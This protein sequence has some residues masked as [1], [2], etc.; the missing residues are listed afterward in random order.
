MGSHQPIKSFILAAGLG[1]RFRPHTL[2]LPKPCLSFLNI[3]F[4]RYALWLAEQVHAPEVMIN[5]HHLPKKIEKTIAELKVQ[6]PIRFSLEPKILGTAG[7]LGPAPVQGWLNGSDP[8][9]M[10]NSDCVFIPG[11]QNF[12]NDFL[13]FHL[14]C[15]PIATLVVIDH[16]P[17]SQWGSVW[18]RAEDYRVVGI[19]KKPPSLKAGKGP[20]KGL[21]FTGLR[22]LSH[23]ILKLI[24]SQPCDIFKDILEP[25]LYRGETV[26]A[27]HATGAF[28]VEGGDLKNYLAETARTLKLLHQWQSCRFL[29]RP[30]TTSFLVS[31]FEELWRHPLP[32]LAPSKNGLSLI[33]ET[34]K[35]DKTVQIEKFAV[36]GDNAEI[37][38]QCS[39]HSS[40][41][42]DNVR[43]PTGAKIEN[44]LRL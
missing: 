5:Q 2:Q 28:W 15:D 18:V 41:V 3:P 16:P 44:E 40:V 39:I 32:L 7:A 29:D 17:N 12:F 36:V 13:E 37:E 8:F 4:V 14:R 26:M 35:V 23:R 1:V 31:V 10:M 21:H 22:L 25:A 27:Y 19:G 42:G 24:A 34:A 30:H 9:M 38:A 11:S 20:L 33:S 43:L 6:Y